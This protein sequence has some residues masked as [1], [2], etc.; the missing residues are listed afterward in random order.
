MAAQDES[1]RSYLS[2]LSPWSRSPSIPPSKGKD[3][4]PSPALLQEQKGADHVVSHR[5]RLSLKKYPRD[6]PPLRPQWFHAVDV[7]K[8]RPHPAGENKDEKP[9]GAPKKYAAFSKRDSKAIEAAF[10]KVLEKEDSEE[11]SK[12]QQQ[13]GDAP[14]ARPEAKP[15]KSL[16]AE[17]K[18]GNIRV[19]V[20]EDYLFDV[21][22]EERE[23]A[24]AYWLGPVRNVKPAVLIKLTRYRSM[25][26]DEA[27]GS[28]K[29][30]VF[31]DRA[32]RILLL[33]WKRDTSK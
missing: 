9:T 26:C 15:S 12:M 20:N 6:C 5:H 10:Q 29:T 31:S 11:A 16:K 27:S 13:R 33:S 21:D 19:P 17:D 1:S 24:P 4:E 3:G 22:V 2:K 18:P 28:T 30:A 7:P 8:R 32:M 23:L 14:H 25:T